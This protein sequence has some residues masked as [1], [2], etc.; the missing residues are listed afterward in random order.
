MRIIE[1]HRWPDSKV[2]NMCTK[3][4]VVLF[5]YGHERAELVDVPCQRILQNA[6]E[7]EA[8]PSDQNLLAAY[9]GEM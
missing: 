9:R 6:G 5:G 1:R 8:K 4:T 7:N 2:A 3:A